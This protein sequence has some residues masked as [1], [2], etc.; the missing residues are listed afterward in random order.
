MK[1]SLN[2]TLNKIKDNRVSL[3]VAK[4]D[5]EESKNEELALKQQQVLIKKDI[6]GNKKEK[7]YFC[8]ISTPI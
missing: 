8:R 4:Q 1:N 2:E 3:V 5:L 6:E 7:S